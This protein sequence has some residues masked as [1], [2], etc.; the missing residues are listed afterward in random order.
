[1]VHVTIHVDLN[2]LL[3][4]TIYMKCPALALGVFV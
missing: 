4:K 3:Q 2:V 1:M